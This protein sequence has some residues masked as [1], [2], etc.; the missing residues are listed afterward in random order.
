MTIISANIAQ[1]IITSLTIAVYNAFFHSL[2]KFPG[3]KLRA[4]FHFPGYYELILGEVHVNWHKLHEQ[5]GD[6]V[7]VNPN[8]LSIIKPEAWRGK[9]ALYIGCVC[10]DANTW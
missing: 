3:P 6:I 10:T 1:Y 5:Y 2:A 7:R 9:I 8:T 4:A